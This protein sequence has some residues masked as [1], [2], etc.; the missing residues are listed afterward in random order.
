MIRLWLPWLMILLMGIGIC[1]LVMCHPLPRPQKAPHISDCRLHR[2]S[3]KRQRMRLS[4]ASEGATIVAH[5]VVLSLNDL[6]EESQRLT[7]SAPNMELAA[8]HACLSLQHGINLQ[9]VALA[10]S[11]PTECKRLHT[12]AL[13][14]S[15]K[16]LK[17]L[18]HR[19]AKAGTKKP[20]QTIDSPSLLELHAQQVQVKPSEIDFIGDVH[21]HRDG[22]MMRSD[23][24]SII[25]GADDWALIC[26]PWI[27]AEWISGSDDLWQL[28]SAGPASYN[29]ASRQ[30]ELRAQP[31]QRLRLHNEHKLILAQQASAYWHAHEKLPHLIK[32]AGDL[33]YKTLSAT[34]QELPALMRAPKATIWPLQGRAQLESDESSYVSLWN[35]GAT[36]RLFCSDLWLQRDPI[37]GQMG[38]HSSG[39][40]SFEIDPEDESIVDAP[41]WREMLHRK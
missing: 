36:Q 41:R 33:R 1:W 4:E 2:E 21:L 38:Y 12:E 13:S 32:L 14:G 9:Q 3:V 5:K 18:Q 6:T 28:E 10:L 31:P 20:P 8:E 37:T 26:A 25:Q 24:A 40:V 39:P 16:A 29:I 23:R 7:L 11:S 15:W 34:K 27:D 35:R 30:L 22:F 17:G 19:S